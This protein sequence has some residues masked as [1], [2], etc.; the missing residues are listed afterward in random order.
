LVGF[1]V[2]VGFRVMVGF[3]DINPVNLLKSCGASSRR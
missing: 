2:V 1:R 3:A